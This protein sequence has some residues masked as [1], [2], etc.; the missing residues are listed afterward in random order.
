MIAGQD[1]DGW[2]LFFMLNFSR[3]DIKFKAMQMIFRY[4]TIFFVMLFLTPISCNNG[5]KDKHLSQHG[6]WLPDVQIKGKSSV[7]LLS[8]VHGSMRPLICQYDDSLNVITHPIPLVVSDN[9]FNGIAEV[10]GQNWEVQLQVVPVNSEKIELEIQFKLVSGEWQNGGV[11]IAFDFENWSTDNYVFVPAAAYNGNRFQVLKMPYP[12]FYNEEQYQK[13]DLSVTITDVPKLT[14][15]EGP[16]K[17]ELLS[18]DASTPA[19]GFFNPGSKKS[20]LLLT[21]V[22][23]SL[24]YHGIIMEES[25]DRERAS[26]VVSAPGVREMRSAGP[27]LVASTDKPVDFKAGDVVKMKFL[28]YVFNSD[29]IPGYFS[30]FFSRRKDLT[31]INSFEHRTPFSAAFTM[32]ETLQ[33]DLRWFEKGGYYKNGNGD[34][35]HAHMQVGWVGGLMQPYPLLMAGNDQSKGRSLKTLETAFDHVQ[36]SSGFFYGIYKDGQVFGDNFE[37]REI[38]PEIAMVRKNADAFFYLLLEFDL[39]KQRGEGH[40]IKQSWEDGL[41]KQAD[42]FVQ[43]WERY[44]Q[45]GQLVNVETGEIF[46]G[47][48]TA[49]AIAPAGLALASMYFGDKRYLEV[50]E[51]AASMYYDRDVANGY[52]TGGPGEILQNP[53][54][55]SAIAM[56]ESFVTLYELTGKKLWLDRARDMAALFSTWVVSY[57]FLFPES[58]IL[59]RS[60]AHSTGSVWASTQNNHSAPGACT[61][62]CDALFRLYRATGDAAYL[63]LLKDISHNLLE[64]MSTRSRPV[65]NSINGYINE[66]VNISDWEG[67][68]GRGWVH[69]SSVSWCEMAVLLT[70]LEIP[71]LYVSPEEGLMVV[72][73]HIDAKIIKKDHSALHVELY[74]PTKYKAEVSYLVE[75]KADMMNP[76][77]RHLHL[78]MP[79][80]VL[81]PGER[82]IIQFSKK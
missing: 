7:D 48:S 5:S 21:D 18:T 41:R 1:Q 58:S 34:V 55:E 71:G 29:N 14:L 10:N 6:S 47:G 45:F 40:L 66:R 72:F 38:R 81:N 39:L 49:P 80:V 30:H 8:A 19:A 35:P 33:N 31:G 64:F 16:S 17:L 20:F 51:A 42:A 65:G 11:A 37:E 62:S 76:L 82:Q 27:E 32:E 36:G 50:A 25:M 73:D 24:G 15:G 74:N 9:G 60:G 77:P 4:P 59:G 44:N 13:V 78:L 56:L 2:I 53:D 61:S 26:L 70:A 68:S 43:L 12:P 79:K 67:E 28:I 54:S 75:N 57:D 22:K 63:D 46:V 23:S 3:S 69:E 52:T